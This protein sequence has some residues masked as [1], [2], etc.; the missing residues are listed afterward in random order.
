[1]SPLCAL[2]VSIHNQQA[3]YSGCAMGEHFSTHHQ[4]MQPKQNVWH[5]H[6]LMCDNCGI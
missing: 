1:L 4:N 6:R 2:A 5:F 3:P